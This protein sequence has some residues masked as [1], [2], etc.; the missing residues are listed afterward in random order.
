MKNITLGTT[1]ALSLLALSSFAY[2]Y[3]NNDTKM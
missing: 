3:P 2:A 1:L